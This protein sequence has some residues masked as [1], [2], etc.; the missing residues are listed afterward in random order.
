MLDRADERTPDTGH[1]SQERAAMSALQ[2]ATALGVSE[3]TIRRAIARGQLHAVKRAGVYQIAPDDLARY[4]MLRGV[5][6]S[7]TTHVRHEPIQLTPAP[8][9]FHMRAF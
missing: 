3:R 5:Q 8:D 9:R 7:S 4:C 2:A 1:D 6:V